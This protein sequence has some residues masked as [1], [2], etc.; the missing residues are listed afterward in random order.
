VDLV[1]R[2]VFDGL[3]AEQVVTL[4]AFVTRVLSRLDPA[5]GR[6]PVDGRA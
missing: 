5:E 1:R 4:E 3:S 2:M 6:A